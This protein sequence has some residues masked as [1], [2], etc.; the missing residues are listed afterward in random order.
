MIQP[1]NLIP[2]LIPVITVSY[3]GNGIPE[4]ISNFTGCKE[5]QSKSKQSKTYLVN[6]RPGLYARLR[7]SGFET[8]SYPIANTVSVEDLPFLITILRIL[9]SFLRVHKYPAFEN[10]D[11]LLYDMEL[12]HETVKRDLGSSECDTDFSVNKKQVIGLSKD[13]Q[14][15]WT[16]AEKV[17]D[18][19]KV[20][21]NY[22]KPTSDDKLPWGATSDIPITDGI[23]FPYVQDLAAWDKET[24][25]S[26]IG[27]Y[28]TRCLGHTTDGCLTSLSDLSSAW[29]RSLHRCSLG[30]EISHIFRVIELAIPAQA[31]V[32]PVFESGNYT[33]CYLS[34]SGFSI[35][36][37]R[38]IF[39][40]AS[41][42]NNKMDFD[43]FEGTEA[44]IKR[45]LTMFGGKAEEKFKKATDTG[46]FISMRGL[47]LYLSSWVVKPE[48]WE[49]IRALA[50]K[51]SYPQE[52]LRINMENIQLVI[53]W[54]KREVAIPIS[55]PMHSSGLGQTSTIA[56][57]LSAFGPSAPSPIVPGA[58]KLQ[59]TPKAPPKFNK[60]LVFRTTT[61]ENAIA[62]WND[63]AEKGYVYN[64]PENLSARYQ[65][66]SVKGDLERDKWFSALHGYHLWHVSIRAQ[67]KGS[68][69]EHIE[70]DIGSG[71]VFLGAEVNF[72]NF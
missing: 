58:P 9:S 7:S 71:G 45:I 35:A 14:N 44:I 13:G 21:I 22:A 62:D 41:Y 37:R 64:G 27:R 69:V 60:T 72:D 3:K 5:V 28:F 17:M 66:V 36:L 4:S 68:V 61:L 39:R 54:M 16:A 11:D 55:A 29:K 65:F 31:R 46:A 12:R 33:G 70:P 43:S 2:L 63:T 56:L 15:F 1:D 10:T 30:N 32:F 38:E 18:E 34:G 48:Q 59:L 67:D 50:S 53:S 8:G 24:T 20:R 25:C 26:V 19:V 23:V 47:A 49:T 6:Y 51:L 52:Y 42:A 40:P 57:A